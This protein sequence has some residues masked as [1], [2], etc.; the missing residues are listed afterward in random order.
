M[1]HMLTDTYLG[2]ITR[3]YRVI[4]IRERPDLMQFRLLRALGCPPKYWSMSSFTV[5]VCTLNKL[6]VSALEDLRRRYI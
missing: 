4:R 1:A 5:D 2:A 3:P 6:K